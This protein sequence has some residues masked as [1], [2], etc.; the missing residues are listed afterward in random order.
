MNPE[1]VEIPKGLLIRRGDADDAGF[2]FSYWLRDFYERSAFCKGIAKSTFMSLH[3]LLLE[4]VVARS[5]IWIACSADDPSLIYGFICVEGPVLHYL[6]VKRRFR[7]LG[8]ATALLGIADMASGPK[9]FTHL[10]DEMVSLRKKWPLAE[11]NPY[12]V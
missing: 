7:G 1:T 2:V 8:I 9:A 4:R 3:H 12:L 10:T 5:V 11:Y 6:Y